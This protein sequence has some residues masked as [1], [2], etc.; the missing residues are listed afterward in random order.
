MRDR[1][2]LRERVKLV[3]PLDPKDE[4]ICGVILTPRHVYPC[5]DG[6][7]KLGY[8]IVFDDGKIAGVPESALEAA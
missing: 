5:K 6:E 7:Y 2:V 8:I 4:G 3:R 1:F